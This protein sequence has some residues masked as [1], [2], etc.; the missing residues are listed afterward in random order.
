[1]DKPITVGDIVREYFPDASDGDIESIVWAE[2]GFPC[3]W[4][5]PEDGNT[6]EECFRKQLGEFKSEVSTKI[7]V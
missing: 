4:N 6:P 5:I 1:M 2:T 3:F 7:P